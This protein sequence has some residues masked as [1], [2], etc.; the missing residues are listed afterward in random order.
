MDG[1]SP[2]NSYCYGTSDSDN[3]RNTVNNGNPAPN[4]TYNNLD[5]SNCEI[6][7]W[8]PN[9]CRSTN[10][11]NNDR[12]YQQ[13]YSTG[14][15]AAYTGA[16]SWYANEGQN[17]NIIGA[18]TAQYGYDSPAVTEPISQ[19]SWADLSYS[20]SAALSVTGDS[21]YNSPQ[22]QTNIAPLPPQQTTTS[23]QGYSRHTPNQ[24]P[25]LRSDVDDWRKPPPG[26]HYN[27]P[28]E[29]SSHSFQHTSAPTTDWQNFTNPLNEMTEENE[30]APE[31]L[32]SRMQ[33][34]SITAQ[35]TL[36]AT[37]NKP[38]ILSKS[39][40]EM[41]HQDL[42]AAAAPF[43]SVEKLKELRDRQLGLPSD[44]GLKS[45]NIYTQDQE[46]PEKDAST[47][48]VSFSNL[49]VDAKEFVPKRMKDESMV[50]GVSADDE[51]KGGCAGFCVVAESI[52]IPKLELPISPESER[53]KYTEASKPTCSTPV[54]KAKEW[55]NEELDSFRCS[56]PDFRN[57]IKPGEISDCSGPL[58]ESLHET[59]GSALQTCVSMMKGYEQDVCWNPLDGPATLKRK[60]RESVSSTLSSFSAGRGTVMY[61]DDVTPGIIGTDKKANVAILNNQ[62]QT[63]KVSSKANDS[64]V[65]TKLHEYK[66]MV[67]SHMPN[68]GLTDG[69]TPPVLGLL[70]L[71]ILGFESEKESYD[72]LQTKVKSTKNISTADMS[73]SP[74]EDS[75]METMAINLIDYCIDQLTCNPASFDVIVP[76]TM[77][78]MS[79]LKISSSAVSVIADKI[80]EMCVAE[81]NF[82][83][84]GSQ[85]CDTLSRT[86]TG[87]PNFRSTLLKKAQQEF[88]KMDEA[89]QGSD[90]KLKRARGFTQFMAELFL[91]L[92][93]EKVGG[94]LERIA[95]LGRGTFGVVRK[96]IDHPNDDNIQCAIRVL[97][98]TILSLEDT[99]KDDGKNSIEKIDVIL[100]D[101]S[102]YADKAKSGKVPANELTENL[103]ES[104]VK[105][106]AI[107]WGRVPPEELYPG[108]G[109]PPSQHYPTDTPPEPE[110]DENY[111]MNEPVFFTP[112]GVQYTA[113]DAADPDFYDKHLAPYSA[114]YQ[115]ADAH[116]SNTSNAQLSTGDAFYANPQGSTSS[117]FPYYSNWSAGDA[118]RFESASGEDDYDAELE[119]FMRSIGC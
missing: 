29:N 65:E 30:D 36:E 62:V 20:P 49:S 75:E 13:T 115:A 3:Y 2:N 31:T 79:K 83:Y 105:L 5:A 71:K 59:D 70:S 24:N 88:M 4:N 63:N 26:N 89:L 97:K 58:S 69:Y 56:K 54:S 96:L 92:M 74:L 51:L 95:V 110:D 34:S 6:G 7:V 116:P 72:V 14:Q 9:S 11:S 94:K 39:A 73:K 1:R 52:V 99:L 55:H 37:M 21:Y 93:S 35:A 45:P 80:Y 107:N 85:L 23:Y 111:F 118:D 16:A 41:L 102:A 32:V 66:K 40:L 33:K 78:K 103:L 67:L 76:E 53:A 86:S 98:L 48:N 68:F 82:R 28:H 38:T 90:K 101:L 57:E 60:A 27:P 50:G 109:S 12:S 77:S 46:T 43:Q 104:F 81:P 18:T 25:P 100:D 106:R 44:N 87:L 119:A 114:Q 64:P 112:N 8:D 22:L 84:L 61:L 15:N 91:S 17:S 19:G 47:L 113:A 117:S 108:E 42:T 10:A